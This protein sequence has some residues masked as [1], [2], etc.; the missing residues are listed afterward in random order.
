L[1]L[2]FHKNPQLLSYRS[3]NRSISLVHRANNG[4]P[5]ASW[6]RVPEADFQRPAYRDLLPG[7]TSGQLPR[8]TSLGWFTDGFPGSAS[9]ASGL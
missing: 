1:H 5:N 2:N 9:E 7:L 3:L 6:G 8:A 4:S